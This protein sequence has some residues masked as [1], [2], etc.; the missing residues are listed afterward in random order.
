MKS[1]GKQHLFSVRTCP[2]KQF[3]VS[4]KEVENTDQLGEDTVF[5]MLSEVTM[6]ESHC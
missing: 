5:P 1:L 2:L 3:I 6:A 4:L